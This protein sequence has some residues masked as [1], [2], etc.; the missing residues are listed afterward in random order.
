MDTI[1]TGSFTPLRSKYGHKCWSLLYRNRNRRS[2]SHQWDAS[3]WFAHCHHC[4][5]W[6]CRNILNNTVQG[7][8]VPAEAVKKLRKHSSRWERESLRQQCSKAGQTLIETRFS[9]SILQRSFVIGSQTPSHLPK[10]CSTM[11]IEFL[12]VFRTFVIVEFP[13]SENAFF[14]TI[15]S[16]PK[17]SWENWSHPSL[18]PHPSSGV[19][20]VFR[21]PHV[22]VSVW[23]V[24]VCYPECI[25]KE[26]P[27]DP[28]CGGSSSVRTKRNCVL[29]SFDDQNASSWTDSR[30]WKSSWNKSR[31]NSYWVQNVF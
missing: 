19:A 22:A 11:K 18:V 21:L 24:W 1:R 17:S 29:E 14:G 15:C 5:K 30:I 10:S 31:R 8:P 3:F 23:K 16:S 25:C 9:G 7:K 26:N 20:F 6:N 27:N 4:R 2:K 28:V 13:L 12:R